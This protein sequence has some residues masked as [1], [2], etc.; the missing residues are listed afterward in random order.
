MALGVATSATLRVGT[1]ASFVPSPITEYQIKPSKVF[2]ISTRNVK[3][4]Q[5]KP[6]NVD[7]ANC[8]KVDF[9]VTDW[10]VLLIHGNDGELRISDAS[11][12]EFP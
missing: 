12:V 4:N 2:Y 3:V 11:E 5:P 9:G 1:Y 7:F 10:D 6:Q 8:C